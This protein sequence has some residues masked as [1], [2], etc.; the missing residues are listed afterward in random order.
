M[1]GVDM[2]ETYYE[3]DVD[4]SV[5]RS[6]RIGIIG[7]GNQGHAHALNLRDSGCEVRI[8]TRPDGSGWKR[9]REA[10]FQVGTIEEVS[11]WADL[12][13]VLLPDQVHGSVYEQVIR[14]HLQRGEMVLFA[15]GFS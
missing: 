11:R 8:G 13:S 4:L 3:R 7:Y 6:R 15:H 12:I 10:E 5:V 9:A 2:G 14:P 1:G